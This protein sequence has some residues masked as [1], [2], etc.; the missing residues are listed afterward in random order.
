VATLIRLAEI[1]SYRGF[2]RGVYRRD[3]CDAPGQGLPP[4]WN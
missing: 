1:G 2:P 3:C 4:R